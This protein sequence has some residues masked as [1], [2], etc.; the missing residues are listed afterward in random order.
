[1]VTRDCCLDVKSVMLTLTIRLIKILHLLRTKFV[2]LSGTCP[3]SDSC[4]YLALDGV[5]HPL[6]AAFSN[7]PTPRTFRTTASSASKGLTPTLGEAPIRRTWAPEHCSS[8]RPKHHSSLQ[9][10]A[11]GFGAGLFPLHSP[12]LGES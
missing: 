11:T 10:K 2:N 3:L 4:Q 12:L 5:Y 6:W 7:N 8:R 1:M 9:R